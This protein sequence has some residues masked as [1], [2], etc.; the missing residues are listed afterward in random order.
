MIDPE[1]DAVISTDRAVNETA[2]A[3]GKWKQREVPHRG[4]TCVDVQDLGEPSAVCEM[5]ETMTTR[6]VHIMEHEDYDGQL[7][8]G[9]VCAEH[10]EQDRVAPKRRERLL[11][12]AAR[13]RQTWLTRK[14]RQSK[15]GNSF[16]NTRGY[17][18]VVYPAA[19][20]WAF[21]IT[22]DNPLAGYVPGEVGKK[23]RSRRSSRRPE[24]RTFRDC[25][26]GAAMTGQG[27]F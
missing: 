18:V 19:G 11:R 7:E 1:P 21:N 5:C 20:A 3:S 13:R 2:G 16:L 15:R 9:C 6:Y 8:V 4:W 23:W 26:R 24:I 14:W 12:N 17:N 10:M 22:K 27:M 25:P